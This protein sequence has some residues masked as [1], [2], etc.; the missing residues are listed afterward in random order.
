MANFPGSNIYSRSFVR[1]MIYV[2]IGL[3]LAKRGPDAR[4]KT[5]ETG[6]EE[7]TRS[8][9]SNETWIFGNKKLQ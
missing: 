4:Q 8:H 2:F 9:T 5:H 3:R 1:A 6:G 7:E